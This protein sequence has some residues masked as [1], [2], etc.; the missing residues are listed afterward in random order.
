MR[1]CLNSP[2]TKVNTFAQYPHRSATQAVTNTAVLIG[3]N[4]DSGAESDAPICRRMLHIRR[5]VW[6][7]IF[8]PTAAGSGQLPPPW[9]PALTADGHPDVQGVWSAPRV[10]IEQ[11]PSRTIHDSPGWLLECRSWAQ[12]H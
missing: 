11:T 9:T 1:K 5:L 8:C 6:D 3:S 12:D 2:V 7:D 10:R 4:D